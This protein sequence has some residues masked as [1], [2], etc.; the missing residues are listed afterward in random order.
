MFSK[1]IEIGKVRWKYILAGY[2]AGWL[3]P[4]YVEGIP[5]IYYLFPIK[6]VAIGVAWTIGNAL[7]IG[8]H[9]PEKDDFNPIIHPIIGMALALIALFLINIV[10][11]VL[12]INP[13]PFY[14]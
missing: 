11:G 1:L 14:G 5:N 4:R 6:G 10:C 2:I 12:G 9:G 3:I 13:R 8:F 7:Y